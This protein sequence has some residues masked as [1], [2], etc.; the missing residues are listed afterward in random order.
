VEVEFHTGLAEPLDH[1]MRLVR[2]AL[3]AG[4]RV[5]VVSP[6]W[7]AMSRQFWSFEAR[8]FLAHARLGVA[9]TVWRRSP[10]WVV[11][12]FAEARAACDAAPCPG[13]WVNLGADAPG[14]LDGCERLIELV[15]QQPDEVD[16]GR[17]RWRAYKERG[18]RPVVRFDGR[19]TA[20][21]PRSG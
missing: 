10:L 9:D 17:L 2:K 1:A 21:G 5:C 20:P 6:R 4:S 19:A 18:L 3:R 15:S 13:V 12:G 7:E 11:S 16:G 14:L 8:E